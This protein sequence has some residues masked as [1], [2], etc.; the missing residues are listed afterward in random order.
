[1]QIMIGN[2][3]D[4][5]TEESLREAL[6]ALV[7]VESVRVYT[8]GGAPSALIETEMTQAQAE[9]LARRIHGRSY[10]GRELRAWVPAMPWK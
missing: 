6:A 3:P 7:P 5:A 2:L 10:Q 8:E 9:A 1:M 4:N